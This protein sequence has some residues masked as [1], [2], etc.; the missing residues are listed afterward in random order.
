MR[1]TDK[2]V[3]LETV[4]AERFSEQQYMYTLYR[5]TILYTDKPASSNRSRR[6]VFGTA[7]YV[8]FI[9]T[10]HTL[11][12]QTSFFKLFTQKGVQNS[13]IHTLYWQTSNPWNCSCRN[14]V[15]ATACILLRNKSMLFRTVGTEK[16][17]YH[18][19]DQ[20]IFL[21]NCSHRKGLTVTCT[22]YLP[23][24]F[25]SCKRFVQKGVFNNMYFILSK[26]LFLQSVHRKR[27]LQ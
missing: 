2:P 18:T 25:F 12:R 16:S 3:P 26:S 22:L 14:C 27:C 17:V 19:F 9:L 1:D 4:H 11:Y 13:I 6:K 21:A 24:F 10:N 23:N 8:Y 15:F 20:I 7:V 5:Q